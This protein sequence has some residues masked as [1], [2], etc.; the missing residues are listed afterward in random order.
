MQ[1]TGK[2]LKVSIY[3]TDRGDTRGVESP[4]KLLDFLFHSG[5]S[6][7]TV[8][9]GVAGFDAN[10]HLLGTSFAGALDHLPVKVEFIESSAKV[11]GLMPMLKDLS[12]SGLIEVQE[13]TIFKAAGASLLTARSFE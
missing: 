3:I 6:G 2:A 7:A 8:L 10:H 4:S 1:Q 5:V 11:E 12:G 13:T 9:K